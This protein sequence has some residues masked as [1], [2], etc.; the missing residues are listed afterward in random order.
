[1]IKFANGYVV[2][3]ESDYD[4][5]VDG[6][7][8]YVSVFSPQNLAENGPACDRLTCRTAV[9]LLRYLEM[10]GGEE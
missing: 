10:Y 4:A 2:V 1:M 9:E 8:V 7:V 5:D 3:A 6:L